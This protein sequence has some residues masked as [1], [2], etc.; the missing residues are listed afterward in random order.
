[1][2]FFLSSLRKE[3]ESSIIRSHKHV[4][5]VIF[6]LQVIYGICKESDYQKRQVK[7]IIMHLGD[8]LHGVFSPA[9]AR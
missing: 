7:E 5:G 9:A 6:I 3:S 1:M 2:F 4:T 8:T